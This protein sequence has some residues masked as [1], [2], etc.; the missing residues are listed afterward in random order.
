[1]L[2]FST[3][4]LSTASEVGNQPPVWMYLEKKRGPL[5]HIFLLYLPTCDFNL[6]SALKFEKYVDC[7]NHIGIKRHS[8]NYL[9]F[10]RTEMMSHSTVSPTIRLDYSE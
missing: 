9:Y 7:T 1:M 10:L 4:M 3:A 5:Y 2:F 8:T 6:I